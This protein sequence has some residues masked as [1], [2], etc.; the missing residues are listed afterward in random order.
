MKV[1]TGGGV[2]VVGSPK[3]F[4]A[5]F[6]HA[7]EIRDHRIEHRK[8]GLRDAQP[9]VG[10]DGDGAFLAQDRNP[11]RIECAAGQ[12]RV[13]LGIDAFRRAAIPSAGIHRRAPRC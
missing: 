2:A 12:R 13:A 10:V 4:G 1:A 9:S 6:R 11:R 8:A 7:R 3:S 5:V